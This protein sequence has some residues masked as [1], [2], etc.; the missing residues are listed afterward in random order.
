MIQTCSVDDAE[1][2]LSSVLAFELESLVTRS[3][4]FWLVGGPRA[5]K[6]TLALNLIGRWSSVTGDAWEVK[7]ADVGVELPVRGDGPPPLVAA[8]R[9][10]NGWLERRSF[11]KTDDSL[12]VE[13]LAVAHATMKHRQPDVLIYL[14][15]VYPGATARTRE[16]RKVTGRIFDRFV[17]TKHP[18]KL[19]IYNP[20]SE[21]TQEVQ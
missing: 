3:A 7:H 14:A 19:I 6:T 2:Y 1:T 17:E 15:G 21:W 10:L 13:G 9:H 8:A 18:K 12:I 5:G 11:Q 4:H 16:E 20:G